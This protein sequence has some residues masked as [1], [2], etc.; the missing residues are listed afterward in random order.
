MIKKL[1][2]YIFVLAVFSSCGYEPIYSS[3]N[4]NFG[5]GNIEKSNN[6]LNN[7]FEKKIL[8][9]SN[10]NSNNKI[11]FKIQTEKKISTKS[12]NSKGDALVF[13]IEIV[14]EI[15]NIRGNSNDRET[16]TRKTTFKNSDDKFKLKQYEKE[17]EEILLSNLVKDLF[18]Y[19]SN[20]Q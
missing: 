2:L 17:L 1:L 18:N 5:I 3:K 20:I 11:D 12:K 10:R 13:E 15:L 8:A 9:L 6:S 4:L 19:L 14:L 7:K 16:F